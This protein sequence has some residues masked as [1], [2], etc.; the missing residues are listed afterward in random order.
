ML[1]GASITAEAR[2]AAASLIGRSRRSEE[3]ARQAERRPVAALDR[4]AQAKAE[5]KR[6]AADIAHHDKLYHEKDAPEISDAEYDALRR[7]NAAIEARF[8]DLV[9]ADSPTQAGRRRAGRG[10]RQGAPSDADAVARQ[11]LRRRGRARLLHAASAISS[12]RRR[13]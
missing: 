10:L 4:E 6:L 13:I 2:A 12:A 7:R 5:L 3:A 11:R 9:R 1:S 8:P